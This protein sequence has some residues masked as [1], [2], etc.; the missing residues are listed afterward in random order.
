MMTTMAALPAES[1]SRWASAR[2]ARRPLGLAVAGGLL[3]SQ[4]VTLYPT[5]VVYTYPRPDAHAA[6]SP[7]RI[8]CSDYRPARPD[9]K[10]RMKAVRSSSV[11]FDRRTIHRAPC[12]S[13]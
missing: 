8:E 13:G 9:G 7:D 11:S 12:V 6:S 1:R 5:P 2:G 3:V 4:L 10:S